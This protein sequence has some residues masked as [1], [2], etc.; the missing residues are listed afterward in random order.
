M[1][2]YFNTDL[3]DPSAPIYGRLNI[4]GATGAEAPVEGGAPAQQA[5]SD[6]KT[7]IE[8]AIAAETLANNLVAGIKTS[9]V[10][11]QNAVIEGQQKV[12][13]VSLTITD[14]AQKEV[15]PLIDEIKAFILTQDC[16]ALGDEYTAMKNALC[17]TI[18]YSITTLGVIAI[19]IVLILIPSL[20]VILHILKRQADN[21][22]GSV[23]YGF[24]MS[25][26]DYPDFTGDS[27]HT[28]DTR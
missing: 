24:Q 10:V 21:K 20:V 18:L 16:K 11:V 12:V 14:L 7:A 1:L 23:D 22:E 8:S 5:R 3:R 19:P 9:S 28:G 17:D 27:P 25:K 4:S 13:N 2:T 6:A 15:Y 26:K